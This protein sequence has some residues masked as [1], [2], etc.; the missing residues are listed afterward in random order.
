MNA[1]LQEFLA[2]WLATDTALLP[3]SLATYLDLRLGWSLVLAWLSLVVV[4]WCWPRGRAHRQTLACVAL[5]AAVSAWLPGPY[6]SA[7]WLALVFQAPST[8]AV[9]LCAW[10]LWQR[11]RGTA[12]ADR[13]AGTNH[14]MLAWA[15]MGA[16][17][18]W[19][20]LLDSFALLPCALY[21]W[22]FSPAASGLVLLVLLLPWI[23]RGVAAPGHA[24]AKAGY[25]A[26]ICL[27][28]FALWRLPTGNVWDAVL[29]PLLWLALHAYLWLHTRARR[30]FRLGA[31]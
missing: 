28:V 7:Y 15:A 18:G 19:C 12:D 23:W 25:L 26:P 6:G 30:M 5:T 1:Q 8:M 24:A 13:S 20:L 11:L 4:V 3:S 21:A 10:L 22:G 9:S 17:L 27:L 2:Q 14:V 31:T 16:L 29:D